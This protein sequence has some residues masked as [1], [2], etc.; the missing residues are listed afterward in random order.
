MTD[1]I[2]EFLIK[3][4]ETFE[5]YLIEKMNE[6]EKDGIIINRTEIEEIIN[7]LKQH[8]DTSNK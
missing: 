7:E 6:R 5:R 2:L 3:T 4:T 1:P 8:Y